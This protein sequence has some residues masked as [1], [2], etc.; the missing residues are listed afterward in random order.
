VVAGEVVLSARLVEGDEAE[1]REGRR[2]E[3]AL[4]RADAALETIGCML[5][6]GTCSPGQVDP[7]GE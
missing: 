4:L 1:T 2:L 7:T 6:V 3:S 5:S